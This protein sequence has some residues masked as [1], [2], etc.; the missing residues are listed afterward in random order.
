MNVLFARALII[1]HRITYISP[2]G[3]VG[4]SFSD[5]INTKMEK[6]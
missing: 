5:R 6:Q 4:L 1:N 2:A 3:P